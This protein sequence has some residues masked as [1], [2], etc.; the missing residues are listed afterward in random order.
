MTMKKFIYFISALFIAWLLGTV[1]HAEIVIDI[2]AHIDG[3]D[4][5]IIKANTLQWHHLESAAVG[6]HNGANSPT[7]IH[8]K[9]NGVAVTE[10]VWLPKWP[11]RPPDEIRPEAFSSVFRGLIPPIPTDWSLIKLFGRGDVK[12]VEQPDAGNDYTLVLEFDDAAFNSSSFY[13]IRLRGFSEPPDNDDDG[14]GITDDDDACLNS[15]LSE[16]VAIDGCDSK[17]NNI[18]FDEGCTIADLVTECAEQSGN[19]GKFIKC[20][21]RL[22]KN[23]MKRKIITGKEKGAI[24]SCAGQADIP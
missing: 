20:V 16:T 8:T 14:D 23:L 24:Q 1:A 22:T 10:A 9:E 21:A 5:L 2:E 18:L 12:I 3:Q 17:V 15:D 19:H 11:K 7:I 13:G 4:Q 6:R